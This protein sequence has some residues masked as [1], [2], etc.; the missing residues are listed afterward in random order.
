[1]LQRRTTVEA[2]EAAVSDLSVVAAEIRSCDDV[3]LG[4]A[5]EPLVGA[6]EQDALMSAASAAKARRESES[7]MSWPV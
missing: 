4:S 7:A 2:I 6:P 3:S 1:M 5:I